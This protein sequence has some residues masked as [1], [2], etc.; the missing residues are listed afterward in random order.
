MTLD[1]RYDY[2]THEVQP[3]DDLDALARRME[4]DGW[5]FSAVLMEPRR[6]RFRRLRKPTG[7]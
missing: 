5:E 1:D 3:G 6:L 4:A 7:P 2:H